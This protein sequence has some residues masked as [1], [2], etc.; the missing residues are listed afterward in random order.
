MRADCA[1]AV[2]L[3]A[4]VCALLV[5][6]PSGAPAQVGKQQFTLGSWQLIEYIQPQPAC[7]GVGY[8]KRVLARSDCGFGRVTVSPAAAGKTVNVDFV[9]GDGT[10]V[11]T[12]AVTTDA[13][14]VAQ[15]DVIPDGTWDP[16]TITVKATVA[17]PD[18]GT[19]SI[20]FELNPL[21]TTP[22]ASAAAYAPGDPV[23]VTG[24]VEELDTVACCTERRTAVPAHVTATLA[25]A[26]GK[27][28]GQ[29]VS[30]TAASDGTYTVSFPGSATQGLHGTP[31][32]D[33]LVNLGVNVRA[34][35]TD[36]TPFV[37]FGT[38]PTAQT[39]GRWSGTGTGAVVVKTPPSTLLVRNLFVS[40]V[41][42]VK[43]GERYPFRVVV[44]NYTDHAF[45]NARVTIPAPDGTTF[46]ARRRSRVPARRR[47]PASTVT[48]RL[49]RR[50]SPRGRPRRPDDADARRRGEGGVADRGPQIVW[51]NLSTTA[52]LLRRRPG[53]SRRA[54]GRR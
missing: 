17:S 31:E 11:D 37:G 21:E 15:F 30:A 33:F 22:Q 20:E 52:T 39:S 53:A 5:L 28:L 38:P 27:A 16:G 24:T 29:P 44:E 10:V 7:T 41:G 47:R 32:S 34:D 1:G 36:S 50:R 18:T 3:L 14:G 54:T 12:Q 4:A 46:S 43:P 40:S 35:Y 26:D 51:K 25:D 6:L 19:A 2:T 48:M 8:E 23:V 49:E 42:W 13:S 45:T 9:D